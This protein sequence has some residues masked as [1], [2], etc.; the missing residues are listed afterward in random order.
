MIELILFFKIIAAIIAIESKNLLSAIVSLGAVGFA[1]AIIMVFLNAPDVAI[2]QVLVEVVLL[3]ILVRATLHRDLT[4]LKGKR[5]FFVK[6][7]GIVAVGAFFLGIAWGLISLPVFGSF[8][9]T[10]VSVAVPSEWYL[11]HGLRQTGISNIV[12]AVLLDYR[13]YDTLGEVTVLF[14]AIL[15]AVVILR[16]KR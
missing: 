7:F 12:T 8:P 9:E 2:V 1:L 4:D 5:E 14:S 3:V 13:A 15:G 11:A 16:K 6:V 10:A